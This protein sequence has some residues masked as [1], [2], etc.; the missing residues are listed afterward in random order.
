M[1]FKKKEK[2]KSLYTEK[3]IPR[4]FEALFEVYSYFKKKE[5][6]YLSEDEYKKKFSSN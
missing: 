2:F 6:E 4:D 1:E 5:G 3:P